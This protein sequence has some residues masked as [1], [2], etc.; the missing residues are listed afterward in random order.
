MNNKILEVLTENIKKED[1]E[2][3]YEILNI[4]K[5]EDSMLYIEW[6]LHFMEENPKIDYGMPGP[7]VH[8]MEKK[9]KKGYEKLLLESIKRKPTEHTVWMLNRILNDVNLEDRNVY[10]D[11]LKAIVKDSKYD[12]ELRSLAKEF[13]EYQEG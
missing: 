12:E 3:I 4:I 11:V 6:I 7:L 1:F 2:A 13:L 9:Y 8:F 10:M 5:E